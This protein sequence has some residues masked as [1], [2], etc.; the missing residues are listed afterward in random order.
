[1]PLT[2][3]ISSQLRVLFCVFFATVLLAG[4]RRGPTGPAF[5]VPSLVGQDIDA[6][7]TKLGKPA[8]EENQNGAPTKVWKRDDSTLSI[9]YKANSKRVTGFT[10]ISREDSD[11]VREEAKA[12]LLAAGKL[13]ES[14]ARY[15][16]ELVE[17]AERPL[18]YSGVRIVPIPKNHAVILRVTGASALLEIGYQTPSGGDQF[19]TLP[20]WEKS[21]S[22]PDDS[23]VMIS[24]RVFKSMGATPFTMKTEIVV[25]GTVVIEAKSTGTPV[26]CEWEL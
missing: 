8:R 22:L 3:M 4:C 13:A 16:V 19:M 5:D 11:A 1:M 20:P 26:A 17:V 15:S 9:S 24:S 23:K 21:F 7:T 12:S 2:A 25:D 6:I 14:D 18:Y 10:L